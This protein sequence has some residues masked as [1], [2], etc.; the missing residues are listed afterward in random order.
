MRPLAALGALIAAALPLVAGLRR[1]V[2]GTRTV[3]GAVLHTPTDDTAIDPR[4]GAVRSVQGADIIVPDRALEGLWNPEHLERLA[5]TYWRS[6]SRF[7]LGLVRVVYTEGERYVVL[8]HPRLRLLTFQAPEYEMDARQGIVRWRIERGLLVAA[9]GR[10]G[11]GYL[12]IDVRRHDYDDW[13]KTRIHVEVEV[14]NFYPAIA[15]RIGRWV[16]VNTQS[17]I[18]V[19]A[20]QFFLRS[21]VRRGLDVSPIGRFAG[22]ASSEEAAQPKRSPV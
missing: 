14:A 6:L 22:P 21:L 11:V 9:K 2:A 13:D 5:R 15:S 19:V 12:E 7:T 8:V 3:G 10:G 17:R 16:Y 20:C 1:L 18:H 4:T